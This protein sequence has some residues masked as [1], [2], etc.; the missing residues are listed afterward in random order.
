MFH[1][2]K[3]KNGGRD[4]LHTHCFELYLFRD[5]GLSDHLGIV[6]LA[7]SAIKRFPNHWEVGKESATFLTIVF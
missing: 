4:K 1:E 2:E 6:F 7:L 5:T 3:R